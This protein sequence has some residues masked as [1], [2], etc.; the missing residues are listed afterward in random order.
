MVPRIV[1][2]LAILPALLAAQA[3]TESVIGSAKSAATTA[4]AADAAGKAIGGAFDKIGRI[5]NN[6]IGNTAGP[7]QKTAKPAQVRPRTA[8]K[9]AA[10]S[11]AV[12]R[13]QAASEPPA[14]TVTYEDPAG[15]QQGMEYDEVMRRFGPPAM[16]ITSGPGDELLSYV[17]NGQSFDVQTRSGKVTAIQKAG[18]A[19]PAK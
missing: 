7:E 4:P 8:S 17:K 14:P 15:I 10:N 5:L 11:G 13:R 16:K 6:P 2:L 1:G 9:A 3:I 18:G 19:D 12:R